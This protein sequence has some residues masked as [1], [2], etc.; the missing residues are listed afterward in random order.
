MKTRLKSHLKALLLAG[1]ALSPVIL[2]SCGSTKPAP[3]RNYSNP[4]PRIAYKP[5]VTIRNN[6][7]RNIYLGLRGPETRYISLPARSSR[8]VNLRSGAYKWVATAKNTRTSSGY[9]YFGRNR[10]YT[11]NFRMN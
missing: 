3:R 6:S 8:G 7:S 5:R 9:K 11:W 2:T 1:L 4:A 10:A